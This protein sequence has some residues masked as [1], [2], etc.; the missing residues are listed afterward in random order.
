MQT[1][2]FEG[3]V[4]EEVGNTVGTAVLV[5]A[6]SINPDTHGGSLTTLHP[7]SG[8]P[9]AITKSGHLSLGIRAQ[10]SL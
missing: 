4:F 7:F 8:N 3:H 1:V 10:A 9:H 2:Y 6:A 5:P